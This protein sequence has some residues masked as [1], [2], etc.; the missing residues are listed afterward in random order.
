MSPNRK[1]KANIVENE[2]SSNH[3]V[4]IFCLAN[5]S[6]NISEKKIYFLNQKRIIMYLKDVQSK[7]QK[8]SSSKDMIHRNCNFSKKAVYYFIRLR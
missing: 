5:I 2:K 4:R 8:V 3:N 7:N 6:F 1:G